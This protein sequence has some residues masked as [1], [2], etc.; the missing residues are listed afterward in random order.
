V[1]MTAYQDFVRISEFT[2][3]NME[4]RPF[5]EA[6]IRQRM[7]A[8]KKFYAEDGITDEDIIV[9]TEIRKNASHSREVDL[10]LQTAH[11]FELDDKH[12][13]L[14][15]LTKNPKMEEKELWLQ[16]R[17]P[18]P[19]IFIDVNFDSE[20]MGLSNVSKI[21]GILIRELKSIAI[22]TD[23][24]KKDISNTHIYGLVAFTTGFNSEGKVFVDKMNFPMVADD[25]VSLDDDNTKEHDF[26]KKFIV[27]F[28][29]FLKDREVIYVESHRD[30]KNQ[31][32]RI[33]VGKM[34]LPSS[35]IIKLTGELKR[36][37]DSLQEN[38][39]RGKL[40]YQFW[41]SGFWRTYKSE[42]YK[43]MRDKVVF[44]EPFKKGKGILVKH[45]YRILP[46][47][48]EDTL[49]YDDIKPAKEMMR[50]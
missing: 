50:K 36:Y 6:S 34:A 35:K 26:I 37:V 4:D 40:S 49:N 22:K 7:P 20:D 18:F 10:F 43:N 17:L 47:D 3:K 45:T 21:S 14:L 11:V 32:R 5:Q 46:K 13:F 28:I 24:E 41:V 16:V 23:A 15:M 27:N 9:A 19:E 8:L 44:V 48:E 25:V 42:R 29:L 12:K 30:K 1:N 31:E 38:D 39:F 33:K 2:K